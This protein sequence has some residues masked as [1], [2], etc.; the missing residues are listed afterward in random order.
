MT[1]RRRRVLS[2]RRTKFL[3][4]RS[5]DMTK[6]NLPPSQ[7]REQHSMLP[8]DMMFFRSKILYFTVH[9]RRRLQQPSMR[10]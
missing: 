8:S 1:V 2:S 5:M 7:A 6:P 4:E 3:S 10:I 9:P